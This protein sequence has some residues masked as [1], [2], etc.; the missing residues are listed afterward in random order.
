MARS[1]TGSRLQLERALAWLR[2]R[3]A[4]RRDAAE[5]IAGLSAAAFRAV[6]DERLRSLEREL[7]EVKSRVNGL[8]FL[9]AGAVASQV[10]LR[11]LG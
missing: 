3:L 2:Q 4:G 5:P 6:V 8:L 1:D 10:V 11:L 7:A 9:L